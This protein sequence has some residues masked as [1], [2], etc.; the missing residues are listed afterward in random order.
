MKIVVCMTDRVI[1]I[2]IGSRRMPD[3][4]AELPLMVW[5]Q[6]GRKYTMI[7]SITGH[8]TR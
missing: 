4:T 5:N 8:V 6:I 3:S 7:K 2:I 1:D